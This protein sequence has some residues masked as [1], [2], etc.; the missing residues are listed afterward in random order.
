M[1]NV[2]ISNQV[3]KDLKTNASNNI[4]NYHIAETIEKTTTSTQNT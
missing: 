4:N 2:D 3:L 1:N